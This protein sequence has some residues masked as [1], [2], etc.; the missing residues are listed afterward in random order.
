[1]KTMRRNRFS[2]SGVLVAALV[3]LTTGLTTACAMNVEQPD[4]WLSGARLVSLGLRGG[5][6]EVELGV[7]NP[8]RFMIRS[9]GLTYNLDFEDPSGD[10]WLDF[11]EGRFEERLR[12]PAGD[13]ASVV[14]PLEFSYR[15]L[16]GAVRS[17]LDRGSFHYRVEGLVAVEEPI[18][19]DIPYRQSG[20]VTP[21][22]VR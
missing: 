3:V 1:M 9:A 2:S 11:A 4:V 14:V 5:T 19:R 22:G 12:I 7:Y 10:G 13:T 17:L 20:T 21:G 18:V 6:L 15:G 8:N 16:G